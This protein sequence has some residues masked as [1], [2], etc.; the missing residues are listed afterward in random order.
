MLETKRKYVLGSAALLLFT[1]AGCGDLGPAGPGAGAVDPE[2]V[3][4]AAPLVH[5][6]EAAFMRLAGEV[7]GF[8]GYFQD[9]AGNRAMYLTDPA[10]ASGAAE[11]LG[12][13]L[14]A[15]AGAGVRV[16][17]GRYTWMELHEWRSRSLERIAAVPGVVF[18]DLDE[19]LNRITVGLSEPSAERLVRSRVRSAGVP[20]AALGFVAA[21]PVRQN[22]DLTDFFRPLTAG[23][24][25]STNQ[26]RCTLGFIV[27]W[28]GAPTFMTASHCTDQFWAPDGVQFF[29][30][31]P[32]AAVGHEWIDPAPFACMG[33]NCRRSD[34]ALV[35]VHEPVN[36][37]RIART[38]GFGSI[39]LDPGNPFFQIVGKQ[40]TVNVGD[41]VHKVGWHT[42]WTWRR[43]TRTCVDVLVSPTELLLCQ[44]FT[45]YV[46]DV[47]DSG[48]PVFYA[49]VPTSRARLAGLHW[50]RIGGESVFSPIRGIESD[51][52]TPLTVF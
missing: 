19:A 50:G 52:G 6:D 46:A 31:L 7:P 43:V 13:V 30:P 20:D 15:E 38:L 4:A 1:A 23:F 3:R 22:V 42:G 48:A 21:E 32:P 25:V 28:F 8:G 45:D 18:V 39:T 51:F 12:A 16:L 49:D 29:Q 10:A 35:R 36:F 33:L 11:R 17:P 14:G 47:G 9:D 44:H 41:T 40:Y 34:A 5:P 27:D 26:S 24:L 2:S 37:A